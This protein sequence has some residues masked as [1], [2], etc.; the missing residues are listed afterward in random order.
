MENDSLGRELTILKVGIY[1]ANNCYLSWYLELFELSLSKCYCSA[2]WIVILVMLIEASADK[3]SFNSD[4]KKRDKETFFLA[5]EQF[6]FCCCLP[7]CAWL[8]LVLFYL[9]VLKL[10]HSWT[11]EWY[12]IKWSLPLEMSIQLGFH[13]FSLVRLWDLGWDFASQFDFV[14]RCFFW[15]PVVTNWLCLAIA[16]FTMTIFGKVAIPK[17]LLRAW[18]VCVALRL[19]IISAAGL[20]TPR[21]ETRIFPPFVGK[22]GTLPEHQFFN[23]W[24]TLLSLQAL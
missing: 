8:S 20:E 12:P 22:R 6:C 15:W 4:G 23:T 18:L 1:I 5:A 17:S 13:C 10:W 9:T 21:E 24:D 11:V 3:L 2:S 16:A 7:G 14:L 19:A